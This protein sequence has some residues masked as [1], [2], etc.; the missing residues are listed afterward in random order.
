LITIFLIEVRTF[1]WILA[2]V[3]AALSVVPPWLRPETSAP[4]HFEHFAIFF[5][6]G[7]AFGLGYH[8]RPI[9]ISTALLLFAALIEIAQIFVPGR[10][11]RLSDFI[12]DGIAVVIGAMSAAL[13][14]RI[15]SRS[16]T[17]PTQK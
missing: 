1:A 17:P 3:I 4:H 7:I 9:L 8:R 15:F 14:R 16:D 10:H 11:A 12:V 5:S 13:A 6:T 2:F